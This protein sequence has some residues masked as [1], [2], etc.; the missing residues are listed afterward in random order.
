[1]GSPYAASIIIPTYKRGDL[2]RSLLKSLAE[3][4]PGR[5]F[6]V[7]VVNDGSDPDLATLEVEFSDLALRLVRLGENRGR[8]FARNEGV[9]RSTGGV[10]IFVDDDMT[11]NETFVEDHLAAHAGPAAVVI[12]DVLSPPEYRSHPLARYVERQGIHKLKPGCK[13]PPKCVRT[14]NVSVSRQLF[15]KAGQF[16]ETI[17]KYGEDLD[18]GMKLAYAGADFK[19][20]PGAKSYHHHPPD[21][22]DMISKMQEY[23]RYTVPL[24]AE[25]HPEL[26]KTIR[27]H[28][29][30]PLRPG[31]ESIGLSLQ[32]I[33]LRMILIPPFYRLALGLYRRQWLGSALFPVI[34]YIRAYNYIREYWRAPK[35]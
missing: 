1:M 4:V 15:D 29:A 17:W 19:F 26:K 7:I 12:G 20:A 25:S 21:I 5:P 13:I 35:P 24:L 14:G 28:L 23:G 8:S 34:D 3:Q 16:S 32:K 31:R 33:G 11:V 18:L 22:D 30:E 27:I 10:I 9:R 6:E 2:L